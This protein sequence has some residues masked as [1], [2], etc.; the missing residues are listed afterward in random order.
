MRA[1]PREHPVRR[2]AV[3]LPEHPQPQYL[4]P[5]RQSGAA[6]EAPV[7]HVAL[8]LEA[9]AGAQ[10]RGAQRVGILDPRLDL[11]LVDGSDGGPAHAKI[12]SSTAAVSASVA[13]T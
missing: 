11:E 1:L 9:C 7:D 2:R 3:G 8:E 4:V 10:Q 5:I 12:A 6:V 13:N